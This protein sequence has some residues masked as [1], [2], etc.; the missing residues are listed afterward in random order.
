MVTENFQNI[1]QY[2]SKLMGEFDNAKRCTVL[3]SPRNL[4]MDEEGALLEHRLTVERHGNSFSVDEKPKEVER[5]EKLTM[6]LI[7][8]AFIKKQPVMLDYREGIRIVFGDLDMDSDRCDVHPIHRKSEY[9]SIAIM[10]FY[11]R[12]RSKP[13]GVVVFEGDLCCNGSELTGFAKSY[14][15]A[16]A[17]VAS[18]AQISFQLTHKFDAITILTKVADF[19]VDFKQGIQGLMDRK[20]KSL[21]LVL[22]DLDDFKSINDNHGYRAG[23]EVLRSVAETIKASVRSKDR[24]SRWGGEEFAVLLEDVD[25]ETARTIAER[26]RSN[27]AKL[28]VESPF[29]REVSVTCSIGVSNV[30]MV[31]EQVMKSGKTNG[32]LVQAVFEAAFNASNIGLKEAKTNGKNCINFEQRQQSMS[33]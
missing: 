14:W 13:S 15:S 32:D 23:N 33:F 9:E 31:A 2:V 16:K 28:K 12:D 27:V 11:Y 17:A 20:V 18:A 30:A 10:P 8:A 7:E 6:S 19:D 25:E 3:L 5:D 1:G 26:A 4:A 29:G 21:Y 24:V 22:I